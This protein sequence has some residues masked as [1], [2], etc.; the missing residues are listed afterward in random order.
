[1][2]IDLNADVGEECGQDEAL[3]PCITSANVACGRHAGSPTTMRETV[4]LAVHHGVAVGAH[5]GFDDREHFGRRDLDLPANQITDLVVR[6]VEALA[7]ITVHACT[8]LQHVKAHGALY[9]MAVRDRNVAEAIARGIASVDSSLILLGLPESEL[10][11]A[12]TAAGLRTARE[13]FADR[14]YRADGTLVPRTEP[15]AV[16][17]D[18]EEVLARVVAIA[19]RPNVDTI[20]VHGD[21]PGAADLARRIRSALEASKIEVRN[22]SQ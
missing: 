13:A 15:G 18:P 2:R 4:L 7:S 3:M 17:H 9:N 5:P 10:V 22:L 1:M 19:R 21:T 16:I 11:A 14:A 8:K 6:Q 20:C 12:G